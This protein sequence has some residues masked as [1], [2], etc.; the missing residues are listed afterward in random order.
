MEG[1][2][3]SLQEVLI[4]SYALFPAVLMGFLFLFGTLTSNIGMLFLLLGHVILVPS[5]NML[6]N[7]FKITGAADAIRYG[8]AGLFVWLTLSTGLF[9]DA[10]GYNSLWISLLPILGL[11]LYPASRV[12]EGPDAGPRC[13]VYPGA[14]ADYFS[15]PSAWVAH[16]IFFFTFVISNAVY[17]YS[18]PTPTIQNPS[19]DPA[20]NENRTNALLE[21]VSNRKNLALT[22]LAFSIITL[23][24]FLIIRYKYTG[25]EGFSFLNLIPM[26]GIATTSVAWFRTI[27]SRCGV[28][29]T[30]IL[31]IVQNLISPDLQDS[32]IVCVGT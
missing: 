4:D 19:T 6:S 16:V 31:G 17:I 9:T 3:E 7:P 27:T 11:L 32:P 23:V 24:G 1:I 29:P 14:E 15:R 25:C 12:P 10:I 26:I 28:R 13:A 8:F 20:V 18:L 5:L 30:D 21:R 2:I 22:I